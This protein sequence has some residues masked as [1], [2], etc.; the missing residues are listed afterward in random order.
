MAPFT[1]RATISFAERISNISNF[2]HAC[3]AAEPTVEPADIQA[4]AKLLENAA[5]NQSSSKEA[6]E[7]YTQKCQDEI[8]RLTKTTSKDDSLAEQEDGDGHTGPYEQI[9]PYR[10]TYHRSGIFST[11]YKTRDPT[12]SE[13]L[14]LKLTIP[15]QCTPPHDPVREAR[16][17]AKATHPHIIPLHSTFRLPGGKLTLVFPFLPLDLDTLL[18]HHHT[19]T[20]N[21][22]HHHFTPEN[23]KSHLRDLFS[24]LAHLHSLGIIHRDI[25]PAN[26]LLAHPSAGPACLA[27]FGIAYLPDES[28]TPAL[29]TPTTP[30]TTSEETPTHKITDV[31]TTAYRPPELLFGH[32]AYS[33]PLDIWAAGCVLAETL[34]TPLT[35]PPSY[36]TLFDPGPLGSDLALIQSIFKTLGTPRDREE[37]GKGTGWPEAKNFPDWGKMQFHVYE[38]RKWEEVLPAAEEE[39]RDLVGKL[40]RYESGERLSAAEALEHA[41]FRSSDS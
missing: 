35:P 3:S 31:G 5:F 13:L 41:F 36:R 17:L 34:T 18:H 6:Q 28:P 23:L 16:I 10:A 2:K 21:P 32:R 8:E 19:P 14:A 26:I 12:T 38:A 4:K 24:A 7:E 25:K 39:A 9:G 22:H 33:T 29:T 15:S 20:P 30:T 11:V 27:D 40:V 1:P 37:G